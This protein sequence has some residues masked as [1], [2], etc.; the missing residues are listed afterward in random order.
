MSTE[1]F[2]PEDFSLLHF[3]LVPCDAGKPTQKMQACGTFSSAEEAFL[4]A[5]LLAIREWQRMRAL[6]STAT[7][8]EA[9]VSWHVIDT[10]FGYDL[11]RDHL[12]VAR[13]WIHAKAKT[14]A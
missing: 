7:G 5:R 3:T 12:V 8:E 4:S 14:Q 9:R 1:L 6:A 10:E 13:F 11:K 2:G